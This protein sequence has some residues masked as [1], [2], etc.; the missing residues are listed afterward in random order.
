MLGVVPHRV[1]ELRDGRQVVLTD[2][3]NEFLEW[4]QNYFEISVCSLG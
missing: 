2:Y 4:A 1:K 3:V